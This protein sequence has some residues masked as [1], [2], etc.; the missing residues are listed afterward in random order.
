TSHQNDG[1]I[2]VT[3]SWL[4]QDMKLNEILISIELLPNPHTSENIK[5]CLNFILENWNL[6]DKCFAITTDNCPNIKKA[7]SLMN[8]ESIGYAAHTLH[9][10]V[11]KSPKQMGQLKDI[12]EELKVAIKWLENTLHLDYTKDDRDDGDYLKLIALTDSE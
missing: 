6:K 8:I 11:I 3:I 12:Q 7:I 2:G 1:Y 10:S 4:D 5:N 9:L